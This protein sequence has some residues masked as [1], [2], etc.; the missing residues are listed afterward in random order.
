MQ[1]A[2]AAVAALTDAERDEVSVVGITLDP[3]NDT[4]A[5]L[6]AMAVGQEIEAPRFRLATGDPATVEALLDRLDVS[7]PRDP[8]T[9]VIDHGN[10]FFVVDRRGKIA[11]RLTIGERQQRWLVA[12]LRGLIAEPASSP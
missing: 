4:P 6:A 2:K 12:A 8:V 11:Y 5:R 3:A 1:Q 10:L 7:R 9:G